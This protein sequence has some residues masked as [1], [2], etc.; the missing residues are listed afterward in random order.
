MSSSR[1]RSETKMETGII[2]G[3]EDRINGILFNTGV[4]L[5]LIDLRVD[6]RGR[7]LLVAER[8]LN[9]EDVIAPHIGLRCK[10]MAE[11][12]RLDSEARSLADMPSEVLKTIS[13][14]PRPSMVG[15]PQPEGLHL[16]FLAFL[17]IALKELAQTVAEG[18]GSGCAAFRRFSPDA[19]DSILPIEVRNSEIE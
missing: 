2:I 14:E 6:H 1:L 7:D 12:M 10:R 3:L 15:H 16:P 18:H 4:Y 17:K 13:R 5:L 8:P 19:N 11:L 9:G